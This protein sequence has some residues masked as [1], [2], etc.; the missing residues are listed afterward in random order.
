MRK[1]FLG[2]ALSVSIIAGNM[3]PALAN[4]TNLETSNGVTV[5]SVDPKFNLVEIEGRTLTNSE[6]VRVEG[7]ILRIVIPR[8][9]LINPWLRIIRIR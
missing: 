5:N 4:S 9:K 1:F 7:E 3:A 2:A 6:A 8:P